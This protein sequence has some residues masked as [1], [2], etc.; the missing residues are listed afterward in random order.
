MMKLC[1]LIKIKSLGILNYKKK[2]NKKDC[3]VLLLTNLSSSQDIDLIAKL[4]QGEMRNE[5]KQICLNQ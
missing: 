3:K 1:I 4:R 5:D 2:T